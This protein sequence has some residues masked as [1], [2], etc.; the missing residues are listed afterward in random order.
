MTQAND[1]G[2]TKTFTISPGKSGNGTSPLP[3]GVSG[4]CTVTKLTGEATLCGYLF[5]GSGTING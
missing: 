5:A 1:V 4:S 3:F 2:I